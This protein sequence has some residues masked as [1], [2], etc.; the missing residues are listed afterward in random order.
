MKKILLS[1]VGFISVFAS[2]QTVPTKGYLNYDTLYIQKS[3]SVPGGELVLLNRTKDSVGALFNKG[4]GRTEFRRILKKI[5]DTLFTVGGD[6]LTVK[7]GGSLLNAGPFTSTPTIGD[8]PGSNVSADSIVKFAFYRSAAPGATLSSNQIIFE[9]GTSNVSA[10][11]SYTSIVNLGTVLPIHTVITSSNGNNYDK[12]TSSVTTSG[13]QSVTIPVNTATTFT[14]TV[15][16]GDNKSGT[17][18]V[19]I[20]FLPGRYEGWI[21]DTTGISGGSFNDAILYNLTKVLTTSKVTSTH[22]TGNPTG[23][24]FYVYMYASGAGALNEFYFN[25]NPSIDGMNYVARNFTN[26]LGYTQQYFIYW[27]KNIQFTSS[28]IS[29]Q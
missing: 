16:S 27:T 1:L 6:T 2:A 11:L 24:Q 20:S 13:T 28:Q 25:G 4:N 3:P 18:T 10:T 17:A 29:T 7:N 14:N 15:T 8:N 26:S 5:N 22:S 12:G 19:S 21:S 9:L 23:Q